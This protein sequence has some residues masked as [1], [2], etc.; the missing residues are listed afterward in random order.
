MP[1]TRG[2]NREG[3]GRKRLVGTVMKS[4]KLTPA[5]WAI[6]KEIGDGNAAE[7]IRRALT[8]HQLYIRR[9]TQAIGEHIK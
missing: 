1:K 5:L 8:D 2:G 7:G 3:S 6:A 9:Q 4:V